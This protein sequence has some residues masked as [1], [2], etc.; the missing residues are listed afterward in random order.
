MTPAKP[1]C[2]QHDQQPAKRGRLFGCDPAPLAVLLVFVLL[3][4]EF[5]PHLW[6]WLL[7]L[8]TLMALIRL[9]FWWYETKYAAQQPTDCPC[10]EK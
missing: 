6:L 3:F 4:L 1:P 8:L 9:G 2:C 10:Q 7:G 5:L